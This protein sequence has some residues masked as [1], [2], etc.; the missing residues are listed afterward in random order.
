MPAIIRNLPFS[1]RSTTVR[2]RGRPV[3][4]KSDQIIVWVSIAE[5]GARSLH[6]NT[7]RLLAILDTGSN[8]NFVIRRSQLVRL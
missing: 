1:D 6:P 5:K 8:H 3:R 4:V 2:V 7:P